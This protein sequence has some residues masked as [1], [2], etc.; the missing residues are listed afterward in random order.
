MGQAMI[1][2]SDPPCSKGRVCAA[3]LGI[4]PT[5]DMRLCSIH[6]TPLGPISRLCLR[7]VEEFE[8]VMAR[9]ASRERARHDS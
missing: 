9:Y 2:C 5:R 3:H 7:C 1:G 8:T 4:V 6:G